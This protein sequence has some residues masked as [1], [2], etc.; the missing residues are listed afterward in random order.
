MLNE[1]F[2]EHRIHI[3]MGDSET[4]KVV[5]RCR[6]MNSKEVADHRKAIVD[7]NTGEAL[8]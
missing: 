6:P 2:Y 7:V 5:V 4:V 8:R 1:L 3:K